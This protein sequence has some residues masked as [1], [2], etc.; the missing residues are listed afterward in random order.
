MSTPT[1]SQLSLPLGKARKAV[2]QARALCAEDRLFVDTAK[3]ELAN[4]ARMLDEFTSDDL[5]KQ[6]ELFHGLFPTHPN[7][8]GAIFRWALNARIIAP[9]G[10]IVQS[11]KVAARARNIQVWRSLL[12]GGS[13]D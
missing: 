5:A 6:L 8:I 13:H 10:R 12:R 7:A 11:H 4:L 1:T 2:G 9:T 3:T